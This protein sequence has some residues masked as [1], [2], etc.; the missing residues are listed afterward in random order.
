[1]CPSENHLSQRAVPVAAF[2]CVIVALLTLV[3]ILLNGVSVPFADEWW[4]AP[5]VWKCGSTVRNR[6]NL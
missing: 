2:L 6:M 3:F 4:Y 5:L 1:M